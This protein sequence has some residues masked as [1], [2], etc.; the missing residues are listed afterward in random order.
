[1]KLAK[2]NAANRM[3]QRGQIRCRVHAGTAYV[4]A[5]VSLRCGTNGVICYARPE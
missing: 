5:E 3:I 2:S 1:M 4:R